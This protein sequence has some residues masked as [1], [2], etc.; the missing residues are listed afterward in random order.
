[1][2]RE[3]PAGDTCE[4]YTV[5]ICRFLTACLVVGRGRIGWLLEIVRGLMVAGEGEDLG[6]L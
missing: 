3:L 2:D 4:D 1:M 5:V 6:G